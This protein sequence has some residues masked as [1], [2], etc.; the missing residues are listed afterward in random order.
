MLGNLIRDE[1]LMPIVRQSFGPFRA[2]LEGAASVLVS[3][4]PKRKR[5]RV[6]VGHA[7]AFT[8]WRLLTREQ[9]LDDAQAA[10]LMCRLV[11]AA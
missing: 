3:G 6:A 9:G 2:Y 4:W 7:L 11:A 10:A 1:P 5:V 8:S